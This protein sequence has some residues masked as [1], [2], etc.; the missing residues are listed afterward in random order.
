MA[1]RVVGMAAN[2]RVQALL[3]EVGGST[4]RP[5]DGEPLHITVSRQHDARSSES[6]E[7]LKSAV[8]E[9]M[10]LTLRGVVD[11]VE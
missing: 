3:I 1:I 7:M 11:W 10:D 4:R 2:G 6:N 5:Q 8:L 9:P